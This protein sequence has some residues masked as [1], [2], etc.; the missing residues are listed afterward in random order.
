M[1]DTISFKELGFPVVEIVDGKEWCLVPLEVVEIE[2]LKHGVTAKQIT[3]APVPQEYASLGELM[4][5]ERRK[6]KGR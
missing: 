1:D 3:D 5:A 6:A 4:V 2:L